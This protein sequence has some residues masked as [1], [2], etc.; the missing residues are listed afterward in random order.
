M[1]YIIPVKDISDRDKS[2]VGG[3]AHAL[4]VMT[5]KG[6]NVPGAII[7]PEYG[8]PCVTGIT[9]ATEIIRS[10]DCVFVDGYLGI[11]I[12]DT[13]RDPAHEYG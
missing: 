8:L 5:K 7:A 10:G 6:M 4:A 13:A 3:K 2:R 11:V 12:I 9:R 1:K